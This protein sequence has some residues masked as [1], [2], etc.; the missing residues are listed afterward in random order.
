MAS[1]GMPSSRSSWRVC[2]SRLA[3]SSR[4]SASCS[5]VSWDSTDCSRSAVASATP[6]PYAESTPA[7]GGTTTVLIPSASATAQAC[8][9]PAPPKLARA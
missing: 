6:M 4:T 3:H 9:P 1:S 8:W 7:S 5:R 2:R